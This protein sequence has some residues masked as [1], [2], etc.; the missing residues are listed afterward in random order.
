MALLFATHATLSPPP[1]L[2][3][4]VEHIKKSQ[5]VA[6]TFTENT[7]KVESYSQD[8]TMPLGIAEAGKSHGGGMK[9]GATMEKE[10][11]RRDKN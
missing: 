5:E 6:M 3:G 2:N 10:E 11:V 8:S 9:A 7:V 4:L 1:Q